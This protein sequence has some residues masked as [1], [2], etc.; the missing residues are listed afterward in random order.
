[1]WRLL[2]LL[3]R[4][5]RRVFLH[6]TTQAQ[7]VSFNMFL[8]FFP[9]M[10]LALGVLGQ[11]ALVGGAA[12]EML[13]RLRGVLPP[14][15]RRVVL[16]YLVEQSANPTWLILGLG[17]TLILGTQVMTD[18]VNGFRL[19]YGDSTTDGFFKRQVR[20]LA[21]LVVTIGPFLAA[22]VLTVFGKQVRD[23]MAVYLGLPILFDLLWVVVYVGLA[24]VLSTLVLTLVYRV[25]CRRGGDWNAVLPGAVLATL[26]WWVVNTLFGA[27]VR[28]MPY[29]KFYGGLGAAIGLIIWMYLSVIVLF[30]GAAFN[31][32]AASARAPQDETRK[33]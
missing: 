2:Q 18:L 15:S 13:A 24:L 25:G 6:G 29:G 33:D 12:E 3:A 32:E 31:A 30:L 10:L 23:W 5:A 20:S 19:L 27:Y 21:L 4:A 22:V 28:Q 16:D 7:A 14:G 26:L 8:A 11:L 17:G 9:M 1:M